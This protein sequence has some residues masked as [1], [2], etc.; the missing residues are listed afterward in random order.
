VTAATERDS[1]LAG[2]AAEFAASSAAPDRFALRETPFLAQLA[3]R[4]NEVLPGIAE[5]LGT[6][7]PQA[8]NTWASGR[9]CDALWL[10]PDEW[11]VVAGDARREAL[12]AALRRALAAR[13]H[14]VVDLSANRAV[15]EL[16]GKDARAI[17]AKG[18]TLDLRA[19]AFRAPHC[20][21]TLVARTQVL[22][23]AMSDRPVFRLFVRNSFAPYLALWLLDAAT[24]T[25][26]SHHLDAEHIADRLA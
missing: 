13:H 19:A 7:L 11:L 12:G 24:E 14:A 25:A 22:V 4:A 10:G 18:C 8:P 2:F 5:V 9:D 6:A 3:V 23:Q 21:Q 15:L 17:L 16:S 20:A 1:P 26:A